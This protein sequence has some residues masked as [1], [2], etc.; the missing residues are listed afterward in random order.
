MSI[1]SQ[2]SGIFISH[3]RYDDVNR[4]WYTLGIV[5]MLVEAICTV[6]RKVRGLRVVVVKR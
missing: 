5:V 6:K 2:S 4:L 1:R 3:T